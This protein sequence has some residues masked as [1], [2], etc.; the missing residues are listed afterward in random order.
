MYFFLQIEEA[1]I[2]APINKHGGTMLMLKYSSPVQV[3]KEEEAFSFGSLVA[4]CGG[5]LGLFIGF[6]FLMVW[7]WIVMA[8]GQLRYLLVARPKK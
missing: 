8:T 4:D 5:V 1:P 7:D 6:N 3:L 2:K